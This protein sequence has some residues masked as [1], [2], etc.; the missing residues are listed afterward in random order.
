MRSIRSPRLLPL[1]LVTACATSALAQGGGAAPSAAPSSAPPA[2]SPPTPPAAPA[3]GS[4]ATPPLGPDGKPI[5]PIASYPDD[6]KIGVAQR[7]LQTGHYDYA[8]NILVQVLDARPEVGRAEF[9]LGVALTKM[10]KYEEARLHLE[11][12]LQFM[13]P[14]PEAKHA[15]HFMGWASYHLG[16]LGRARSDFEAH[17]AEVPNEPD[18]IFGLGLIAFDEDRLD[19]AETLFQKAIDLQQGPKA[20]RRDVSKAWIRMGDVSMR[21][22]DPAKAEERYMSGLALFADHYEGWAKLARCRDQMGKAKEAESARNEERRARERVGRAEPADA[23]E[24]AAP[25]DKPTD[26]PADKPIDKP[27]D[28]PS[29][30]PT[31]TTPA[32]PPSSAPADHGTTPTR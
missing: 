3:G 20:S 11:R 23:E 27:S 7:L 16:E 31:G 13:Q 9:F 12:S 24:G 32:A 25:P 15:H 2:A 22:D 4:P 17:L 6:P 28:K 14:F 29:D 21:R 26:K 30:R 8:K 5:T 1:L 19:D 10:K 18:S